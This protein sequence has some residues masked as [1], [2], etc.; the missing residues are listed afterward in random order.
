LDVDW[1]DTGFVFTRRDGSPIHPDHLPKRFATQVRKSQVPRIRLHD[2]PQAHATL[3]LQ[4][5]VHPR[6][7][8]ERLGHSSIQTTLDTYTH[9]IPSM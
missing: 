2:P 1:Q 9:M 7:V 5:G 8:C 6:V 3:M 4:V